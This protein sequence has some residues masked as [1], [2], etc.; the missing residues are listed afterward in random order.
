MD[1]NKFIDLIKK[2][3]RYIKISI[4]FLIFLYGSVLNAQDIITIN[5][6]EESLIEYTKEIY[7]TDDLLNNGRIYIPVNRLAKGHPYFNSSDWKIGTIFINDEVYSEKLLKYDIESDNIIINIKLNKEEYLN[8]E[9]NSHIIDSIYLSNIFSDNYI[10]DKKN[11]ENYE[12]IYRLYNQNKAY[13]KSANNH[14]KWIFITYGDELY[15]LIY[16]G[17]YSLIN[18]YFK[19]FKNNYSESNHYGSYTNEKSKKYILYDNNI[20]SVNSKKDFID[21]FTKNKEQVSKF[22][23]ENKISYNKANNKDLI[24][25]M[26]FCNNF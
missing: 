15:E 2:N 1:K 12:L 11:R 18:K 26:R 5:K 20:Y 13:L 6:S 19:E 16:K 8:I 24:R 22:I 23:K 10:P 14:K 25:L 9:L 4:I 21:F 3:N 7:K 17:K